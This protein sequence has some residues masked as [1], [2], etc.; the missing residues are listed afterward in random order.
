[1]TKQYLVIIMY[2]AEIRQRR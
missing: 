1:M 2:N